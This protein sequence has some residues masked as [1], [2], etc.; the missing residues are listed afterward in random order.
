MGYKYC[1]FFSVADGHGQNG[2]D[3]S[4]L[5][6]HRLPFWIDANMRQLSQE[7]G[8]EQHMYPEAHLVDDAMTR[9]FEESNK[10]VY[11]Q[12]SDVRFSGSTC[13]SLMVMGRKVFVANVGDSRSILVKSNT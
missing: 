6:K 11:A 3:V 1:H 4:S 9:A 5:L 10:E 8:I 7:N 2:R 13:T 12:V